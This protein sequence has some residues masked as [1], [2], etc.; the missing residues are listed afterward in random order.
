MEV[1]VIF[2]TIIAIIFNSQIWKMMM[3]LGKVIEVVTTHE[4]TMSSR[5]KDQ[6]VRIRKVSIDE[7]FPK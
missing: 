1:K 3:N 7:K 2:M 6:D 4:Y 5:I